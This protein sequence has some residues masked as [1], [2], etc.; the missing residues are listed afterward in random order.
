M[1]KMW[2]IQLEKSIKI[3]GD[4]IVWYAVQDHGVNIVVCMYPWQRDL[5]FKTL[6]E[7]APHGEYTKCEVKEGS[8]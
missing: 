3:G 4:C 1:D 6:C 5:V 2:I 8:L 7:Y